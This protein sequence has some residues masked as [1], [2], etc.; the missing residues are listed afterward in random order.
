[1]RQPWRIKLKLRFT[2]VNRRAHSCEPKTCHY[3]KSILNELNN[4]FSTGDVLL[5]LP[6][7]VGGNLSPLFSLPFQHFCGISVFFQPF[8]RPL[9]KFEEFFRF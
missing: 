4:Y 3:K 7:E 5:L 1:M 8:L 9:Y 6:S 2:N